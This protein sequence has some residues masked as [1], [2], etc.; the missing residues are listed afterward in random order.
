MAAKK[1]KNIFPKLKGRG[2]YTL[3]FRFG[4][5]GRGEHWFDTEFAVYRYDTPGAFGLSGVVDYRGYIAPFAAG[6]AG[7]LA[8]HLRG[9]FVRVD[10]FKNNMRGRTYVATPA[11]TVTGIDLNTEGGRD[12][13]AIRYTIN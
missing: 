9:G 13:L 4:D 1:T 2:G 10:I 8:A 12:T 11:V 3:K 7:L 6:V 5:E